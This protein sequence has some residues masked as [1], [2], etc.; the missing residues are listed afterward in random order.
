MVQELIPNVV[1]K[2]VSNTPLSGV[3]SRPVVAS[4]VRYCDTR[5]D[6]SEVKGSEMQ[7]VHSE[8]EELQFAVVH[9]H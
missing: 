5:S 9:L 1:S 3:L 7:K 4:D 6:E 8:R 2:G